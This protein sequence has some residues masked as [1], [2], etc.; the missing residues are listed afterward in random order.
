MSHRG[1]S[2]MGVSRRGFLKSAAVGAAALG[3]GT[4]VTPQANARPLGA[5]ER[6]NIGMIGVGGRGSWLAGDILAKAK[7][8]QN[9]AITAVCDVWDVRAQDVVNRTKNET[10][11]DAKRFRDYRELIEVPDL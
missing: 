7:D 1:D 9:I 5:N 6:I 8:G 11:V 4:A 2:A 3:L 10:G